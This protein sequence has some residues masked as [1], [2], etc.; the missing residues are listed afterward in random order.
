MQ[1]IKSISELRT[2]LQNRSHGRTVGL[3]PT[4][5]NLHEGHLELAKHCRDRCDIVVA[6]V[7]VNPKQFGE[8]E[9]FSDYPRTLEDDADLLAA[10]GTD[11]VFAPTDDAMYPGGHASAT[12]ISVTTLSSELCGEHRPGHFDGVA[13]V[14]TKLFNIVM[15]DMAFFGEKDWQQL[16]ILSRMVADLNMP[17]QVIGV[18]TVRAPDGLA[19]S[20]RNQYLSEEER[21]QAPVL[22]RT[23]MDIV[24]ALQAGATSFDRLEHTARVALR[25]AGFEVDY[26]SIRHA[27]TLAPA[28]EEDQHYRVLA[29]AHLGKARLI[30]NVGLDLR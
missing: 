25:S 9:D 29:A 4:M 24:H 2:A 3:V 27:D 10:A 26:V 14:V 23:L 20:S 21:Q 18:P 16:T 11:Y 1:I 19:L 28:T 30:D 13:T 22:Y 7:F 15:P 12:N 8:A 6:S 17:I 5:G